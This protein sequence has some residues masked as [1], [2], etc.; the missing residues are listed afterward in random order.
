MNRPTVIRREAGSSL[1]ELLASMVILAFLFF[2]LSSALGLSLGQFR[3]GVDRSENT[4]GSQAALDWIRRDLE[5]IVAERY[6]NLPPLP[7]SVTREQREF[8][9]GKLFFPVEINRTSG[10][11]Q[12]P[13]RIFVNAHPDFDSVAF[14]AR[15]PIDA[16]LNVAYERA[17]RGG[18][19]ADSSERGLSWESMARAS[20]VGYYVAYTYESPLAG[21][22]RGAMRLHRHYRPGGSK[23]AQGYAAGFAMHCSREINDDYDETGVGEA[24]EE[25]QANNAKIRNGL[26]ANRELPFLF[27]RFLADPTADE[28]IPGLQPWPKFPVAEFLESPPTDLFPDRGNAQDWEDP[29]SGVHDLVFPDEPIAH[30]VVRFEVSAF[31]EVETENDIKA[32]GAKEMANHLGLPGDGWPCLV[33]PT[34]VDVTI[35]VV[36]ENTARRLRSPEDWLVDW[37]QTDPSTWS[38]TRQL[39]ENN[40]ETFRMRVPVSR[41][42]E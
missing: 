16:Q 33:T 41:F 19:G 32:M 30:N 10:V 40:Q 39:I 23:L 8:F 17:R 9:E 11:D 28:S 5:S 12:D 34:F 36:D 31:R 35:T 38:E 25:E 29:G 21:E 7:A 13:P 14:L 26:F 1:I 4:I 15:L 20:I 42:T 27:S 3:R 37:S 22:R 2:V 6:G 24:R 18:D